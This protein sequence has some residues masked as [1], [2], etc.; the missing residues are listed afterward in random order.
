MTAQLLPVVI[1]EP[2]LVVGAYGY[3]NV[4]DEAIL[5]GLLA[6]LSPRTRV[7]VIS[8]APAETQG[9][10]GVPSVPIRAAVGELRRHRS[11]L[12]GGGGLF[13]R[14]LGRVGSFIAPFGLLAAGSGRTVAITSVGVDRELPATTVAALRVLAPRL[15]AFTVRDGASLDALRGWGIEAHIT[16]DLSSR[17]AAGSR[18][19]A[20][21]ILRAA[22]LSMTR[23]IVGLCLADVDQR[24]MARLETAIHELVAAF[25][26]V[27]FC[28]IPMS[29]H[30]FVASH[31]DLVLGH[32][33]RSKS[34]E[35]TVLGGLFPPADVVAVF[36]LLAAAVCMRYHSLLFAE[37]AGIPVVAIPY[38]EKCRAWLADRGIAAIEPIGARLVAEMGAV[39]SRN[40]AWSA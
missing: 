34:P 31:N 37:R 40:L 12:I 21:A 14:D 24:L 20:Q 26:E 35:I 17:L 2:I 23:P 9:L 1:P 16:D 10:H 29:Q 4:G 39:L 5:A 27:Q 6:A 32:R 18:T 30:P 11:V 8:R 36:P 38:A 25:P 15:A 3:R 7:S 19:R 28:F 33:L 13:G 22:G